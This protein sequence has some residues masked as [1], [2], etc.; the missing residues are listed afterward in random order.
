MPSNPI[1]NHSNTVIFESSDFEQLSQAKE[2]ETIVYRKVVK[3][4]LMNSGRDRIDFIDAGKFVES[5]ARTNRIFIIDE[6]GRGTNLAT[7]Q[8]PTRQLLLEEILYYLKEELKKISRKDIDGVDEFL[9]TLGEIKF[10]KSKK[11]RIT[12]AQ[13]GGGGE[14]GVGGNK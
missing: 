11:D 1:E 13:K 2:A 9:I 4:H 10:Q 14:D 3:A 5:L 7:I 8:E 6:S 12:H